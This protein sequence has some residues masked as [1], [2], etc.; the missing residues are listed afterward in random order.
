MDKGKHVH[1]LT[2]DCQVPSQKSF[3]PTENCVEHAFVMEILLC[4]AKRRR[5]NVRSVWLHL[6]NAFGSVSQDLLWFMLKEKGVP[7]PLIN[8]GKEIY[9]GSSQRGK[10]NAGYTNNIPIHVGIKQGCP[11]SP[12]FLKFALEALLPTLN[13]RSNG[14]SIKNESTIKQLVFVDDVC[15]ISTSKENIEES[16][17]VIYKF[18]KWSVLRLNVKKSECY[19]VTNNIGLQFQIILRL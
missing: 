7:E 13:P 19:S 11:L 12:L 10:A 2:A 18:F 4:D 14:Y 9:P 15:L 17:K 1:N 16:L 3:L 8:I 6:K 5:R